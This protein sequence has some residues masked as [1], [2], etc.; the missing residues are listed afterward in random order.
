MLLGFIFIFLISCSVWLEGV[1]RSRCDVNFWGKTEMTKSGS[2]GRVHAKEHK[3]LFC[4]IQS[5]KI[6]L[7]GLY[8]AFLY[9]LGGDLGNMWALQTGNVKMMWHGS[10]GSSVWALVKLPK[11][12]LKFLWMTHGCLQHHGG[13]TLSLERKKKHTEKPLLYAQI[14]NRWIS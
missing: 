5:N 12:W 2:S 6:S 7:D 1:W 14:K 10:W 4:K 9:I 8:I 3:C 13:S 11:C